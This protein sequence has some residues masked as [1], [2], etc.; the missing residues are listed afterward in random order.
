VPRNAARSLLR[1]ALLPTGVLPARL[2]PADVR[3][4][5][6]AEVPQAVSPAVRRLLE[7]MFG[8][9]SLL[10]RIDLRTGCCETGCGCGYG[11]GGVAPLRRPLRP[12]PRRRPP[13]LLRCRPPRRRIRRLRFP[14]RGI[15]QAARGL[16]PQLGW[17][18]RER[19]FYRSARDISGRPVRFLR[20]KVLGLRSSS[21]GSCLRGSPK[22]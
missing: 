20:P 19:A 9:R 4:L 16:V 1:P 17:L 6:P 14:S 21:L 8:G 22:S 7:G 15:Y 13:K 3:D 10:L 12:R 5:L 11:C 2:L 18:E